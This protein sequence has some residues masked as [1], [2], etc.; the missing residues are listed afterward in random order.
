MSVREA[1]DKLIPVLFVGCFF[2]PTFER[3]ECV[4]CDLRDIRKQK[5]EGL[6]DKIFVGEKRS[7]NPSNV[8][9]T[10]CQHLLGWEVMPFQ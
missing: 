6:Q 2:N 9:A 10:C 8:V 3:A 4:N 1:R 7:S 5:L